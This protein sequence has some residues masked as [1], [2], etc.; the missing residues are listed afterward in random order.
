[1][2]RLCDCVIYRHEM[3]YAMMDCDILHLSYS[4]E[5]DLDERKRSLSVVVVPG[6][7]GGLTRFAIGLESMFE[8]PATGFLP[9]AG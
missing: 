9:G 5:D 6:S 2:A 3:R 1:M 4:I 8:G 7:F